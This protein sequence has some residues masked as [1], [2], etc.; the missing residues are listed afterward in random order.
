MDLSTVF[1]T[2]STEIVEICT[3]LPRFSPHSDVASAFQSFHG[4]AH[5]LEELISGTISTGTKQKLLH[6]EPP[7]NA[8]PGNG[9]PFRDVGAGMIDGLVSLARYQITTLYSRILRDCAGR[10]NSLS[11]KRRHIP[12]D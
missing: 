5:E 12:L 1:G 3:I 9:K 4:G 6:T 8:S 2:G 7:V 11:L 10:V